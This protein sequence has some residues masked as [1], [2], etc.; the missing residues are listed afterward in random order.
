MVI[1]SMKPQHLN[2]A[3]LITLIT[4]L[5]LTQ[6]LA[7]NLYLPGLPHMSDYSITLNGVLNL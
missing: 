3:G 4:T 2:K 6:V 1:M 5:S 7:T